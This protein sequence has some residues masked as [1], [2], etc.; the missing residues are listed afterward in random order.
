MVDQN[1]YPS[2]HIYDRVLGIGLRN[3]SL[4]SLEGA[5]IPAEL[6]HL[7]LSD[8]KFRRIPERI[9]YTL[10]NLKSVFLSQN[11]WDCDCNTLE[12]R[13]WLL[14]NSEAVSMY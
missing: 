1:V 9:L 12:F 6:I 7:D 3:N 5:Q 4:D 14:S 2:L 8:N 10:Q 13:K 11:P